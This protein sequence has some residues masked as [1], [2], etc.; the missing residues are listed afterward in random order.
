GGAP[1]GG[2]RPGRPGRRQRARER[3]AREAAGGAGGCR[4]GFGLGAGQRQD[5]PQRPVLVRLGQKVQALS[6]EVARGDQDPPAEP[7]SP[8]DDWL[9]IVHAKSWPGAAG[10]TLRP[11]IAI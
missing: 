8:G 2:D 3:R 10:P 9:A 1:G 4:G 7:P 5:R 6:W 11:L